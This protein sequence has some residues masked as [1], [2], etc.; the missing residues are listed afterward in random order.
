MPRLKR[1][2]DRRM[3]S[4]SWRFTEGGSSW[5]FTDARGGPAAD[6]SATLATSR[7]RND[8]GQPAA[9]PLDLLRGFL[10]GACYQVSS[11]WRCW[12]HRQQERDVLRS[13]GRVGPAL[14]RKFNSL[15][16]TASCRLG[17]LLHGSE[18]DRAGALR[19]AGRNLDMLRVIQPC[20]S[21]TL[22]GRLPRRY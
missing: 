11:S 21:L 16:S 4:G 8:E 9:A 20:A 2:S 6:A 15:D 7:L 14:W 10:P 5:R 13:N 19:T 1:S 12:L 22:P 3:F 18:L 17:P